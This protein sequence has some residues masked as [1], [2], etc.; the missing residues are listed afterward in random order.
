MAIAGASA[1]S[2]HAGARA[3][4]CGGVALSLVAVTA[5]HRVFPPAPPLSAG[6]TLA[7]GVL[8]L[9]FAGAALP[10]V[11]LLGLLAIAL[12]GLTALQSRG[13]R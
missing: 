11:A 8:A 12:A 7:G 4:L 6:F 13:A 3:A 2:L 9:A 5:V 10:P 1:T